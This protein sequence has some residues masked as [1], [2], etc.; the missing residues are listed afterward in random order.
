MQRV[1]LLAAASTVSAL[2]SSSAKA[3]PPCARLAGSSSGRV[4]GPLPGGAGPLGEPLLVAQELDD[5]LKSP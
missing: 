2:S 3:S 5:L 1:S 4:G